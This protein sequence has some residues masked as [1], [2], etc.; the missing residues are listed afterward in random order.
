MVKQNKSSGTANARLTQ[1][2]QELTGEAAQLNNSDTHT[3]QRNVDDPFDQRVAK[4]STMFSM[5]QGFR[6]RH[7]NQVLGRYAGLITTTDNTSTVVE[8]AMQHEHVRSEIPKEYKPSAISTGL[9]TQYHVS[10]IALKNY[11]Q[12][13]HKLSN[14]HLVG[15]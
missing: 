13:K 4:D 7:P 14:M 3:G 6:R 15:I 1:L 8:A 10:E 9:S 11:K 12:S 2:E 5:Q